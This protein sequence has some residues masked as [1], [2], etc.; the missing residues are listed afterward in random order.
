MIVADLS[1]AWI[2][3][4]AAGTAALLASSGSVILGLALAGRMPKR[5]GRLGDARTLH[6]A[7]GIAT[8]IALAVHLGTLALDPWLAPSLTDLAVPFAMD[9]RGIWTGLGILAG[10][11][12]VAFAISGYL[13]RRIG[14]RWNL[15]HRFAG[16]A[17]ALAVVHTLGAGS[18]ASQPWMLAVVGLCVVPVVGLAALRTTQARRRRAAATD[19]ARTTAARAVRAAAPERPDA[20]T[21]AAALHA[22]AGGAPAPVRRR[23]ATSVAPPVGRGGAP[24][25]PAAPGR[26]AAAAAPASRGGSLWAHEAPAHRPGQAA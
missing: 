13:R 21:R 20:E 17:W 11:G 22:R 6:Q 7:F 9:Y 1:L 25:R 14:R 23:P 5:R 24:V 2:T 3:T 19:A 8:I 18:D 12:L 4:R 26:P 10:Y 15:I 16:L